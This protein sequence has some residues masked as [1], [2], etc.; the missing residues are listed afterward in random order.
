MS[1]RGR[2]SLDDAKTVWEEISDG[3]D[4]LDIGGIE[5]NSRA[6]VSAFNF[7]KT[8]QQK[9]VGPPLRR[10]AQPRASGKDAAQGREFAP[11]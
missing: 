1:I 2:D 3:L 7:K 6:Y 4:V 8:D 5:Q 9:K 10:G 11:S